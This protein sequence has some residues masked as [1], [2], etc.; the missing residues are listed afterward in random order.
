LISLAVLLL[1]V[2]LFS[3]NWVDLSVQADV[4]EPQS[5]LDVFKNAGTVLDHAGRALVEGATTGKLVLSQGLIAYCYVEVIPA[6]FTGGS[7][8]TKCEWFWQNSMEMER[9]LPG[10]HYTA[11]SL[12]AI[13]C[14]MLVFALFSTC[15]CR[16]C[17]T[18]TSSLSTGVAVLTILAVLILAAALIVFGL[19]EYRDGGIRLPTELDPD[20]TLDGMMEAKLGSARGRFAWGCGVVVG[21][22]VAGLLAAV[23][24]FVAGCLSKPV[25]YP[26]GG[27]SLETARM[28]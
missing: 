2:G 19:F 23:L 15:C 27:D 1:G 7:T 5:V 16:C 14:L 25:Q 8:S 21:G 4:N 17:S 20:G 13:G 9:S 11:Q 18:S 24:L 10:W 12:Y 22:I 26:R 3:P 28:I 6:L